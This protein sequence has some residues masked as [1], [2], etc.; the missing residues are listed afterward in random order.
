ME[1][2]EVVS[3]ILNLR[4]KKEYQYFT[5]SEFLDIVEATYKMNPQFLM[6]HISPLLW[7]ISK[8]SII[9]IKK[10]MIELIK[11]LNKETGE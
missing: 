2:K 6:E 10:D 3:I 7:N 11:K 4:E 5:D 1:K 8:P 9:P